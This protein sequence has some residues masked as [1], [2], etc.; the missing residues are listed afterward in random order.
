MKVTMTIPTLIFAFLLASLL[1][2]LYH[3]IRGGGPGRLFLDLFL[4]WAGFALGYF[5]GMRLGWSLYP[6]GGLDLGLTIPAALILLVGVDWISRI[7]LWGDT[8][9][10]D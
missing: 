3:L 1:G 4:S 10:D 8:F 2:A 6:L 5:L 9:P 7:R